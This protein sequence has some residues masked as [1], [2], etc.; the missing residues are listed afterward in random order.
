MA[1]AYR[2]I[3]T[4]WARGWELHIHDAAAPEGDEVGVTTTKGHDLAGAAAMVRDYLA[5]VYD[6]D[7]DEAAAVPVE[8]VPDLGPEF[9]ALVARM[10]ATAAAAEEAQQAAVS[11][12]R[13]TVA[14]LDNSGLTGRE[15]AA[16]LGLSAQRVSQLLQNLAKTL[17]RDG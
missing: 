8:V 15:M 7:E 6:L 13:E 12:S 4:R 9:A 5:M 10:R 14:Y 17:K 3:A 1:S 16:V 2:V 11:A